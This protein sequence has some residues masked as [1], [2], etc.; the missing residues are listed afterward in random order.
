MANTTVQAGV[1]PAPQ[2]LVSRF[3]GVITSPRA[4]FAAVAAHPKWLGM[5]VLTTLIIVAGT[6]LPMTTEAGREA[7]LEQQVRQ[8]ES[9]G[10]QVNDQMYQQMR[11]RIGIAPYT[12]AAAIVVFAPIMSVVFAAIVFAIFNAAMGGTA[13]FKQVYAVIVHAGVISALAQLFTGPMN[14]L[15]GS[16]AS[17]TNLAVLLPMLP[18]GSFAARLAGMLDLFLIWWVFVLA[19]GIGVLYRR[20]TQPIAVSLFAV[21]AGIALVAA[22]V[23]S[24]IGRT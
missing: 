8:M 16:M 1:D 22:A 6:T 21:Y 23:M 2:G 14:Y 24:R 17:A 13:T 11:S 7:L 20:R 15:R 4:T 10:M 18:E 3:I 5:L 12:S 9:F 19:I